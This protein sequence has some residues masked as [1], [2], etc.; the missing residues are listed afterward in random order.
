MLKNH[1]L[2][3]CPFCG[4]TDVAIERYRVTR[5]QMTHYFPNCNNCRCWDSCLSEEEA[6]AVWNRR[7]H[8]PVPLDEDA[9]FLYE[10]LT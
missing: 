8:L 3:P 1:K 6:V 9:E 5:A 2:A 4:S 10:D 7:A